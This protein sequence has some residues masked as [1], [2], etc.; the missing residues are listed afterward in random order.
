[1]DSVI[2]FGYHVATRQTWAYEVA[3]HQA[4]RVKMNLDEPVWEQ[5]RARREEQERQMRDDEIKKRE[6]ISWE[7][8]AAARCSRYATREY[9]AVPLPMFL[10]GSTPWRSVVQKTVNI[11]RRDLLPSRC[12]DQVGNSSQGAP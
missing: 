8:L 12:E 6:G 2:N 1:M 9:T 4:L 10:L 7:G 5:R 3:K 11:H